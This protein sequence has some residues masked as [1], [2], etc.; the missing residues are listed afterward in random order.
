VEST[1]DAVEGEVAEEPLESLCARWPQPGGRVR[2][3]VPFVLPVWIHAWWEHFGRGWRPLVLAARSGGRV[4]GLAP[5][6]VRG[7]EARFLGDVDVCDY[8]D[9]A[10]EPGREQECLTLLLAAL[11]RAGARTLELRALRPESAAAR[12]L[13]GAARVLGCRAGFRGDG[14]SYELALSRS[15]EGYLA[16]LDGHQ[17]HEIRRKLRR[18]EEAA[19]FRFRALTAPEDVAGGLETFFELFRASRPDKAEFM[20]ERMRG[21]FRAVTSG[22][23]R[24]GKARLY[25]L[26][27]DGAPAAAVLCLECGGT[28]YL[29]NNGFDPRLE[30][31]SLGAVSKVL[32]VRDC[33]ERGQARYDFLKGAEPYKKHLGGKAVPLV[34]CRVELA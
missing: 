1:L 10:V 29:Y 22:M 32:T 13:Q 31:L 23:A 3:P 8:L 2:W 20:D 15:W 17:R 21:F 7:R 27:L 28:T 24:A 30:R 16:G 4:I 25:L 14:V 11:R 5:L 34:R 9:V 26:D 19:S 33:I 6:R 12:F 18:M